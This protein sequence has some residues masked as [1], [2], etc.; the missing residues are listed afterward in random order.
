MVISSSVYCINQH[1][2]LRIPLTPILNLIEVIGKCSFE[3]YMVHIIIFEIGVIAENYIAIPYIAFNL[4]LVVISIVCGVLVHKIVNILSGILFRH[5]RK[6][7]L[8]A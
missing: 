8:K 6:L 1:R 4:L 7:L 5:K 2:F 3:I